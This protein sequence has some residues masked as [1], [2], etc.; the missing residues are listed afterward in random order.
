MA[1]DERESIDRRRFVGV[2][3]SGAIGLAAGCLGNGDDGEEIDDGDAGSSGGN[4]DGGADGSDDDSHPFAGTVDHPGDEPLE[5]TGEHACPVCNMVP[6]DYPQWR[7]Q[8]A[9]EGGEGVLFD[10]PG[11]LFAYSVAQPTDAEITDV[12]VTDFDSE[13]LIDGFEAWYVIVTDSNAEATRGEVMDIN[14]R[15]FENE[16]DAIDYLDEWDAEEL[17]EDD[18]IQLEDV[19]RETAAIYRGNRLPDA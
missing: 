2:V 9:L 10:T 8:L 14:P 12:W 13:E 3:G 16:G 6:G 7:A 11:C 15:P 19:D 4:G 1:D 18:V 17:T 5:F